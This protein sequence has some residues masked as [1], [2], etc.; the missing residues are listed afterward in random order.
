MSRSFAGVFRGQSSVKNFV[1]LLPLTIL[2]ASADAASYAAWPNGPSPSNNPSFFP[3]GVWLQSATKSPEYKNIGINMYIGFYGNLDQGE[4]ERAGGG[5]N[6]AGSHPNSVGLRVRATRSSRVGINCTNPTT[7]SPTAAGATAPG[8]PDTVVA[9]YNAI[10]T[11]DA[12]RPV[13]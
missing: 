3:I 5:S 6:A 1:L 13:F 11:N 9:A 12:T 4:F 10:K 8:F 7:P 2:A